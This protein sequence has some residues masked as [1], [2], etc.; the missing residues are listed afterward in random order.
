MVT[1]QLASLSNSISGNHRELLGLISEAYII[2]WTAFPFIL[3]NHHKI[4]LV[5]SGKRKQL[6]ETV[7]SLMVEGSLLI[8]LVDCLAMAWL[9]AIVLV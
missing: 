6:I 3:S 9:G 2:A 8:G 7:T 4:T 1:S 5:V